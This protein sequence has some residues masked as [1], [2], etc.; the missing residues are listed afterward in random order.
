MLLC[1]LSAISEGC[2]CSPSYRCTEHMPLGGAPTLSQ[3]AGDIISFGEHALGFHF[4]P[5]FQPEERVSAEHIARRHAQL[6]AGRFLPTPDGLSGAGN[7]P[8]PGQAS[9]DVPASSAAQPSLSQTSG[10]CV[11][12][13]RTGPAADLTACNHCCCGAVVLRLRWEAC[14]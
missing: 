11:S 14:C 2:A 6:A 12:M 9:S 5:V 4:V 7:V 13:L 10:L 8:Q 1:S 3:P